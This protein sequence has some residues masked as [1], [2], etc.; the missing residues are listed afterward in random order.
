[1]KGLISGSFRFD[2]REFD[3]LLLSSLSR[4]PENPEFSAALNDIVRKV[5]E[6]EGSTS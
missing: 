5:L 1:M 2:I 6:S 4:L 3:T